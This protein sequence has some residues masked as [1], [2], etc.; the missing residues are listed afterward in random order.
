M[1]VSAMTG[2][3]HWSHRFMMSPKIFL[4]GVEQSLVI[5]A[6]DREGIVRRNKVDEAGFLCIDG[7]EFAV[8]E[9]RGAVE[10]VG[11]QWPF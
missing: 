11:E 6:D 4:D 1:R 8:E 3:H 9:L 2:E 7:D 10:I 5:E